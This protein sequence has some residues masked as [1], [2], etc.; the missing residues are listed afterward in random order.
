VTDVRLTLIDGFQLSYDG[1]P[2]SLP[3]SS[4]RLVAYL[5]LRNRPL[6][7]IH[8]AGTLWL[9]SSEDRSYANLRTALWR[10]G[11]PRRAVVEAT[12]SHVALS[13]QV[14]VDVRRMA[15]L[16]RELLEH[17]E[18]A[19][20]VDVESSELAGDL[21]PG[22]YDDWVLLERERLRQLRLHALEKL[23]DT[24]IDEGRYGRAID[25]ALS[26]V[27]ADPLRESAHR[28]L[29][30]A[31]IA[32][33]NRSVAMRQYRDYCRLARERL[34]IGPSRELRALVADLDR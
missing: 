6:L 12:A 8:V 19:N 22:W 27:Q 13:R 32:E 7:R 28:V 5:A 11:D 30:R 3:R 14:V 21:L 2:A 16:A 9:N 4:Q 34:T 29:I 18:Q 31:H 26:A 17:P 20:G 25:M 1:A 23:A 15:S 24:A 33:G 10:L